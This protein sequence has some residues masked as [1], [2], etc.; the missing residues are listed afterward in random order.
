MKDLKN[1][2]ERRTNRNEAE[3]FQ[4]DALQA[5]DFLI[6]QMRRANR[7]MR[8][9]SSERLSSVAMNDREQLRSELRSITAANNKL[10]SDVIR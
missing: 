4:P 10:D 3:L 8:R 7:A 2:F 9:Y 1:I 5:A 6:R